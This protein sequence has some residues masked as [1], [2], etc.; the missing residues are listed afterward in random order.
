MQLL[1]KMLVA[2]KEM[3]VFS[4]C[5]PA[6]PPRRCFLVSACTSDGLER[7]TAAGGAGFSLPGGGGGGGGR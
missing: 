2:Y 4:R 3:G 1:K 5:A 7:L 6:A